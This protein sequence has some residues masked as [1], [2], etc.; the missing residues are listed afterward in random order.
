M[1]D[2][3]LVRQFVSY[4]EM[5]E[6]QVG[7]T[8]CSQGDPADCLYL[9]Y[10]GRVTVMFQAPEGATIR[11]RSMVQHTMVGEMG[12]Y[13]TLPRGASVLVDLPT[14]VYRLSR[15]AMA[16]MEEDNPKLAFAFHKFVVRVMAARLD[17]ANREVAALQR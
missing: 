11:L 9:I 12:L 17:F 3:N 1:G 8:I 10:S 4:L 16:Q 2:R 7:E 15:D 6:Y 13:R 5:I 14:I